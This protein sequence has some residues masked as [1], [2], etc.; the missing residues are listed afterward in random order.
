MDTAIGID[1]NRTAD[2]ACGAYG[3]T[4]MSDAGDFL[5]SWLA[6]RSL[7]AAFTHFPNAKAGGYVTW[8][9]PR[10]RKGYQND[11]VFIMK[12]DKKKLMLPKHILTSAV[13]NNI[14]PR[15]Q[16]TE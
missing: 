15:S 16:I 10:P 9:H 7:Y 12:R 14:I 13:L 1:E 2:S 5:R 4:H 11:H 6:C 3:E 8:L